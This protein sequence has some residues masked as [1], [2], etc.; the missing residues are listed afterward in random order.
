MKRLLLLVAACGT[1]AAAAPQLT[2]F[3]GGAY[4]VPGGGQPVQELELPDAAYAAVTR[5]DLGDLRVF[6]S[7]GI[8]VPHALCTAPKPLPPSTHEASLTVFPLN[9]AH[10]RAGDSEIRVRSAQG[11]SVVITEPQAAAGGATTGPERTVTTRYILDAT[12][13]TGT[14]Q[15]L[16]FAWSAAD[17]ASELAVQVETS[18]DLLSWRTV[19]PQATLLRAASGDRVLERAEVA[20]PAGTGRYLRVERADG[21]PPLLLHAVTAEVLQTASAAAPRRFAG[22]PV[23]DATTEGAFLFDTRRLAPVHEARVLLPAA[24]MSVEAALD[25]RSGPEQPWR[26]RW[27]GR[28]SSVRPE[29]APPAVTTAAFGATSDRHWRLRVLGGAE[30]LGTARPSL[31]F[32]YHPARLQFTAQGN[33][34]WILAWGGVRVE[35]AETA[36]CGAL[37]A[38]LP[39]DAVG[40]ATLEVAPDARFGGAEAYVVPPKPTPVRRIV[41]WAVLIAG[42]LALVAM[43]A[44]LMKKLRPPAA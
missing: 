34:P 15:R 39:E 43:A 30:T 19:V 3:H 36:A 5:A 23:P 17:G 7:A 29:G 9:H 18:D 41:L 40:A 25:S 1:A 26:E 8:A 11:A 4:V 38:G 44:S 21:G 42:T 31:E 14:L 32:G 28:A 12:Q 27:R 33:A 10:V 37:V 22:E 2:D 6:N 35:R 24:N 13:V 20:L 16:R